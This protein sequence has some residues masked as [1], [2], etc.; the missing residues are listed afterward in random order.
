[1][2]K[3]R[4]GELSERR[5][6]GRGQITEGQ[7]VLRCLRHG[8]WALLGVLRKDGRQAETLSRCEGEGQQTKGMWRPAVGDCGGEPY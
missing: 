2:V 3:A 5:T 7:V 4:V 1:M 6:E 8:P